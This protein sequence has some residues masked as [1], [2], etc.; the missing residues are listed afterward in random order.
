M[1]ETHGVNRSEGEFLSEGF[2]SYVDALFAIR[3]FRRQVL[4]N[5]QRVLNAKLSGLREATGTDLRQDSIWRSSFHDK[6]AQDNWTAEVSWLTAGV[7][8]RHLCDML[9]G[10]IWHLNDANEGIA[11]VVTATLTFKSETSG[12][13]LE[14]LHKLGANQTGWFWWAKGDASFSEP[15]SPEAA[16]TFPQRLDLLIDKW[17]QVG[18][19]V[20][21][22]KGLLNV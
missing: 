20:G 4:E 2:R 13:V 19:H 11:V 15:L 12:A 3:A 1:L 16:Q 22:L 10:L 9:F 21:G 8:L 18:E 14:R 5:C 7:T 17:I 6:A